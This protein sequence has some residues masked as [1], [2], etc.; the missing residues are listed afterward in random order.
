MSTG[1][2]HAYATAAAG[3]AMGSLLFFVGHTSFPQAAFFASG[4]L[5]G[6]V[7]GPDLDVRHFTHAEGVL[8][9]SA[10]SAGR[11]LAGIWYALWWPYARLIPRHRHPLSH[12]PLV[13][14]L[15]RVLYLLLVLCLLWFLAGS[16]VPLPAPSFPPADSG[17]WWALGGLA[18]VDA[19]HAFMDIF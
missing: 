17:L 3:G 11:L 18:L 7:I 14:T 9:S 2:I 12:F 10:G 16:L 4:C 15:G 19:L 8:R 5:A 6:L 1:K 13:G